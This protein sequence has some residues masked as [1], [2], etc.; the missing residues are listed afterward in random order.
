MSV[1]KW[2]T[3]EKKIARRAFDDALTGEFAE[4]MDEL[5]KRSAKLASPTDT[6]DMHHYLSNRLHEIERRYD[7]RY[8]QLVFVFGRL[9][10]EKR[11]NE[12]DIEGLAAEKIDAIRHIAAF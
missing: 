8:S 6:W 4:L 5:R 1:D 2:S 11:L 7:F 9:M 3:A 10:R 12:H